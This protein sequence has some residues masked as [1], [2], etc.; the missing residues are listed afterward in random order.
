MATDATPAQLNARGGAFRSAY[1]LSRAG[2]SAEGDAAVVR[3]EQACGGDCASMLAL[4]LVERGPDGWVRTQLLEL[5]FG[6]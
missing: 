5:S 4:L 3:V 2:F 1:A 6:R